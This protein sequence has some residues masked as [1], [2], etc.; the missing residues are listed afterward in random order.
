MKSCTVQALVSG[1]WFLVSVF[2]LIERAALSVVSRRCDADALQV[3][4]V[5]VLLSNRAAA[6]GLADRCI[7]ALSDC[8]HCVELRP[9]Y[10]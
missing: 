8:E 3:E 7:D 1:F 9:D 2:C 4:M 5:A 6:R 10:W